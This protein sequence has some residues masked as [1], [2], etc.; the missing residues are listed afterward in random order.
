MHASSSWWEIT[1]EICF[2]MDTRTKKKR[3]EERNKN[4]V[5]QRRNES[6]EKLKWEAC[7][8]SAKKKTKKEMKFW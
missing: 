6:E 4:E 8:P 2:Q 5:K 7:P 3:T 1:S